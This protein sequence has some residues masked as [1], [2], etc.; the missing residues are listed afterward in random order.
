MKPSVYRLNH[1]N[2]SVA[3]AILKLTG[4]EQTATTATLS[5]REASALL[6]HIRTVTRLARYRLSAAPTPEPDA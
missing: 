2:R 1:P 6:T 5:L 3:A 4:A